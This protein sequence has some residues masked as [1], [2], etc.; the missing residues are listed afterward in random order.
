[1][2]SREIIRRVVSFDGPERIGFAFS[3]YNGQP[4]LNDFIGGGASAD[5]NYTKTEWTEGNYLCWKDQWGNTWAKVDPRHSGEVIRGVIQKWDD[6]DSYTPPPL[7]DPAL[8]EA[9]RDLWVQ[10]D[11][12]YRLGNIPGCAFNVT[13][14]MRGFEQYLLDC[15]AE[16]EQVMRLN[17]MVADLV[18][19]VVDRQAEAGAD[20]LFFCEDWGTQDMLLVSPTMWRRLFLPLFE[21]L[22]GHAHGKG[23]TVWMHSCGYLWEIIPDLVAVGLDVLQFDQQENY[24]LERLAE[25]FAGKITFWCPVDIQKVLQTQDKATIQ[26]YA[27]RMRKL[28]GGKGGGFVCKD[29]GDWR[30]LGI[31][32]EEQQWAY[33]AFLEV[34]AY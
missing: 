19:Q 22:I 1:M 25:N 30:A 5:P 34:A 32:E 24:P 8:Y 11:E 18:E 27:K 28:L 14:Y 31:T 6:L 12:H 20:G 3:G 21:R 17:N 10:D 13:R 16:P 7:G 26:A 23:L 15:A 9:T 33:E 29:Y 2:T 4:R